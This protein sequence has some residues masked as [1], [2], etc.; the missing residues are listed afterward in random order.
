MAELKGN[1]LTSDPYGDDHT[2]RRALAEPD[3]L[4]SGAAITKRR[5]KIPAIINPTNTPNNS[6]L[7]SS[8]LKSSVLTIPHSTDTIHQLNS[9]LTAIVEVIV[10]GKSI[11]LATAFSAAPVQ[12][13][14]AAKAA[15]AQMTP[16][17]KDAWTAFTDGTCHLPEIDWDKNLAPAPTSL[18]SLKIA[19][20]R[21]EALNQL[22]TTDRAHE[23]HIVWI[24]QNRIEFLPL[25]KAM[26]RVIGSE[27]DLVG[28]RDGW[29]PTECADLQSINKILSTSQQICQRRG[30]RV[31]SS[32]IPGAM[33]ALQIK[34]CQLQA[35]TSK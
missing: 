1:T 14:T 11:A 5:K 4:G 15:A 16:V 9:K 18:K 19:R 27:R 8:S 33:N 10:A 26:A 6:P 35:S 34:R 21:A 25:I 7:I 13:R 20:R 22:Y 24:I 28:G 3:L 23:G 31:L 30:K 17:E 32:D 29:S 12:E 2:K